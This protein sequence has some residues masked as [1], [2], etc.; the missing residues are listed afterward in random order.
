[1]N[2]NQIKPT[3]Q[4]KTNLLKRIHLMIKDFSEFTGYSIKCVKENIFKSQLNS[5]YFLKWENGEFGEFMTIRSINDLN[6]EQ[7]E[8][9]LNRFE[10]FI[11][12]IN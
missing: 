10:N 7:L 12:K 3:K 6:V 5:D 11:Q 1:M 2:N 4:T 8:T 9:C